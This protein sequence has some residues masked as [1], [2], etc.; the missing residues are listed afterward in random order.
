M[1]VA[2][3]IAGSDPSSGAGIQ[4][5]L[6]TFAMLGVYGTSAITTVTAQNTR[7]ITRITAL[8]PSTV[9]AQIDAVLGDM[10]VGAVK[11]GMV[12]SREIVNV[13]ARTLED[14][15]IPIVLDPVFRA[16]T[17]AFLLRD[18]AYRPFV[19]KLIPLATVITPNRMEAERLAGMRIRDLRDARNAVRRI[20]ELGA[21]GVVVKGGHMSGRQST[22]I[23]YHKGLFFKFAESRLAVSRMH[24]AGGIFSAALAAGLA[25]DRNVVD[26][27]ELANSFTRKAIM[28]AGKIGRG[29]PV[30]LH[31]PIHP[32]NRL[33]ASLQDAVEA[34]QA[35]HNL[36]M[37]IPESQSNFVVA[38]LGAR[39]VRDVAGVRGRIVKLDGEAR[40]ADAVDFGASKH[41]A[42]AVLAMMAHDKTIRSAM[43]IRYSD[44]LVRVC[45]ELGLRVSSYDR[46]SEPKNI[47][48]KEGASVRW[49]IEQAVKKAGGTPDVVYH[50]GDWGKEPMILVFG[51]DP[52]EVAGRVLAILGRHLEQR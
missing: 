28:K 17:G 11:I 21:E 15:R 6:K 38:K 23:L 52:Q 43:N 47:K 18:D 8:A 35:V 46:R 49:G 51:R 16:G 13:V 34:L 29:L 24:G 10:K 33:P 27:T 1:T 32:K 5:D 31:G 41:V 4:A 48:E 3:T 19:K 2:L 40:Q 37:I 45:R 36:G 30:P 7:R 22:D 50:L 39:S 26:A 42:S 14:V 12:Y 25:K 20:A 44:K 9:R